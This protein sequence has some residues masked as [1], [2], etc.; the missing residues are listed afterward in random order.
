MREPQLVR[1][2]VVQ[3][4]SLWPIGAPSS[5]PDS[6]AA[7][8]ASAARACSSASSSVTLMKLLIEG[9]SDRMRAS[10]APVSSSEENDLSAS[11]RAISARVN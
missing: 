10:R 9:S 2:P 4:R 1:T 6:P 11:P 5:G 3:N 7:R 8:R